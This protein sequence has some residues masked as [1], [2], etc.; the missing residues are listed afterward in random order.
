MQNQRLV[1]LYDKFCNNRV[2]NAN[3]LPVDPDIYQSYDSGLSMNLDYE[4]QIISKRS[5]FIG[6][7]I[8]F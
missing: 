1:Y 7:M 4:N 5:T 8:L 2:M 3:I 6:N